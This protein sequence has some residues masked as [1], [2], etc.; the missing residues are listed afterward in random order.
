MKTYGLMTDEPPDVVTLKIVSLVFFAA[1]MYLSVIAYSGDC[2]V[3]A[4][5]QEQARQYQPYR[6]S[7][8]SQEGWWNGKFF[9]S[10]EFK[11]IIALVFAGALVWVGWL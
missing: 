9:S 8:W 2:N 7:C 11:D 1:F 3:L 5:S 10:T 4:I 6:E